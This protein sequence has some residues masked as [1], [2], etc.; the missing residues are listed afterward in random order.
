M[1]ETILL[2]YLEHKNQA[3]LLDLLDEHSGKIERGEQ[4]N[5][6]LLQSIVDYFSGY[7]EQCHHPK[8]DLVFRKLQER[9][10]SAIGEPGYLLREHKELT[11]I[12]NRFA[13]ILN[14]SRQHPDANKD[15]LV[16]IMRSYVEDYRKHMAMEEELFFPTAIK[17]L[18]RVDW[19]EIDF[20]V[21]DRDDPL[22]DR[23]LEDRYKVLRQEISRHAE[24]SRYQE[25][26]WLQGVTSIAQFN[27]ADKF[28]DQ[29]I[30]LVRS[31][32]GGY[33][34]ERYGRRLVNFPECSEARAVWCAYYFL[35]G[36]NGLLQ[37]SATPVQN[38]SEGS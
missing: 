30:R 9:N 22:F 19:L 11:R 10:A 7:P 36:E 4:P 15:P 8:E 18:S 14:D 3:L 5:L 25:Q 6:E 29:R 24:A 27:Q 17:A 12:T 38:A 37:A 16:G 34:L 13:R 2:L 33:S 1:P 31:G 20:N 26:D 21:F 28:S 23:V 35:E 32:V